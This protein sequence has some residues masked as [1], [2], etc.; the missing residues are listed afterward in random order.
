[1]KLLSVLALLALVSFFPV[2]SAVDTTSAAPN[3]DDILRE[4]IKHS[5][6]SEAEQT[7]SIFAYDRTSRVEYLDDQ[8]EP[9]RQV[10]RI[11]RVGPVN[12]KSVTKLLSVNG[13]PAAERDEKNRSA[14]RETGDK[15]RSLDLS[16]DILSRFDFVL[17][18]TNLFMDRP[19]WV[20][21]FSPKKDAVNNSFMDRLINA[22]SGTMWIDQQD[23]QMAKAFIHL[24]RKV[25]FFGGLAGA[26]DRLDLQ[27]VQKRVA[28]EVWLAEALTLDLTGRKLFSPIRFRCFENCSGF[29][30]EAR[31]QASSSN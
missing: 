29:H 4:V 21:D 14:A 20:L 13:H 19:V 10:V 3:V 16:A 28:P 11:Y 12:G 2:S 23:F 24:S 5:D 27:L 6:D 31:A 17:K 30:Q 18:G 25:S 22:M 9:K 15:S 8:G 1:V 26:I 7:R